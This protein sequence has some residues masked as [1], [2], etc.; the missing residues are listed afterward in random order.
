MEPSRSK[1]RLCKYRSL[2]TEGKRIICSRNTHIRMD[3]LTTIEL[4]RIMDQVFIRT[5]N[6]TVDRYMPVTT[7][8]IKRES[9]EQYY[10]ELKEMS[11]NFELGNQEDTLIRQLFNA[12]MQ[13]SGNQKEFLKGRTRQG[14]TFSNYN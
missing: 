2:G 14:I 13:D 9:I 12:N 7:K 5:R 3:P 1:I 10:E 4:W 8:E 11:E 6:I